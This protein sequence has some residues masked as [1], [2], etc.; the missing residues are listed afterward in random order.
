MI[1]FNDEVGRQKFLFGHLLKVK[2]VDYKVETPC[3]FQKTK[4]EN[5]QIFLH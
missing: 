5:P 4:M 3:F 2:N 1:F